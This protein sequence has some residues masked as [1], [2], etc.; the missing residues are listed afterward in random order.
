M[1]EGS[2]SSSN[3]PLA[4]ITLTPKADDVTAQLLAGLQAHPLFEQLSK[5][6]LMSTRVPSRVKAPHTLPAHALPRSA[7]LCCLVGGAASTRQL[8]LRRWRASAARASYGG[9]REDA[10]VRFVWDA[11]AV[12]P[13]RGLVC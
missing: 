9:C 10:H 4:G 12:T 8:R 1:A 2:A 3:D 5:E 6:L 7:T 11:H 13:C